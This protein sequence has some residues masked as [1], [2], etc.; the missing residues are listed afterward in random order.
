MVCVAAPI[1][2]PQSTDGNCTPRP[3]QLSVARIRIEL[4]IWKL[5]LTTIVPMAFGA[6][7]RT[8]TRRPLLPMTLAACTYSRTRSVSA[9]ARTSRAVLSHEV[10]AMTRTSMAVD[11]R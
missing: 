3:S 2:S 9:S 1:M 4:A 10:P 11:G 5:T 6:M 8:I 7:C